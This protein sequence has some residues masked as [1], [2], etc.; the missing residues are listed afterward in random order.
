M[1]KFNAKGG[2]YVLGF[3]IDPEEKL[4]ET[5][6]EINSLFQIY[7]NSPLFGVEFELDDKVNIDKLD[8]N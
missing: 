7:S 2:S 6:K 3:K 8:M 4:K 5:Y 1:I